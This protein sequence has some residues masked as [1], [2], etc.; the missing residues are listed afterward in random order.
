VLSCWTVVRHG[1]SVQDLQSIVAT[2]QCRM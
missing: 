1:L 2:R